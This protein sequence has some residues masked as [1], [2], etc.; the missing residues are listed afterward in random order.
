[1]REIE[2]THTRALLRERAR[3]REIESER[4]Q[5]VGKWIFTNTGTVPA[6]VCSLTILLN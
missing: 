3:V 6:S 2:S 5:V 1:V 4:A